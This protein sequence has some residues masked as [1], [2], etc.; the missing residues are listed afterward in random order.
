[1]SGDKEIIEAALF[2]SGDPL[3]IEQLRRL[4]RGKNARELIQQLMDEYA[5]RG[6]AIEIREI[7]GRFVMQVKP[8]YAEK[9]RSVAPKELRSPVLRTLAM[10]A[11]H[12]PLTV[13]ELVYRR[14]AAAYDHVRE[15][16]ENG[17]VSATPQGRTRLLQTTTR[18]AEY[19]NLDS[20]EPE[21][22]KRKI[23]ELAR[24][25]KMGLDKWLGKQGIGVTAMY[26]SLMALSGIEEYEVINPYTPTD[27]TRDRLA[28]LG[29]LVIPK[30]YEER[31]RGYFDGRIIEVSG[32]TFEE[33]INSVNI[34]AE[35]GSKRKV[36]ESIEY[37][38]GL[39]DE[40]IE[41]AY[42]IGAKVAP[43]TEMVSRMVSELRLGISSDGVKIAPDYG[44][45]SKGKEIGSGADILIPTHKNAEVDIVKRI[46]QR[47]DAV[48]E[49][50]KSVKR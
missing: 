29:V 2:A 1:M 21:A 15:L 45:S 42:A 16:E 33:L 4:L 22:I 12:Q 36:R 25:Q 48:I 11:Y 47:Y 43:Q 39:K 9:V 32:A 5:Q 34:L 40:Y 10:I 38:S 18:F 20:T 24:E 35:Y 50:L 17:L 27:E 31:V 49:G 8:E 28:E 3:D 26:E 19:F 46:C 41:K 6:S 30:G 44:T 37:I 13:A 14:G 7:E 23:I